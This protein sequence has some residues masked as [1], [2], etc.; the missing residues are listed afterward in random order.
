MKKFF[1]FIILCISSIAYSQVPNESVTGKVQSETS[2]SVLQNVHVINLTKVKE[3]SQIL[4]EN[5]KSK[6]KLM[7]HCTFLT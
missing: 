3:L 7:I 6:Q 4:L 2:E 5:L 1:L